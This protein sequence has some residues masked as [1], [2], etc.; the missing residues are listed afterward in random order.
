MIPDYFATVIA[1]SPLDQVSNCV[2]RP[3]PDHLSLCT[4]TQPRPPEELYAHNTRQN[5]SKM[6]ILCPHQ[7][8]MG[9]LNYKTR[10]NNNSWR[11]LSRTKDYNIN[12]GS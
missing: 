11:F 7:Y 3:T 5:G 10:E 8:L 1:S 2:L 12:N 6:V 9:H 4:N